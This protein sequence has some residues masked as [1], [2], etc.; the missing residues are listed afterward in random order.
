M[1]VLAGKR[2][3]PKAV[4][5]ALT[6]AVKICRRLSNL[7]REPLLDAAFEGLTATRS[8]RSALDTEERDARQRRDA[9][10]TRL[11]LQLQ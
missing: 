8:E 1:Q 4:N 11:M 2:S 5:E 10:T 7:P 9:E 6:R 3:E